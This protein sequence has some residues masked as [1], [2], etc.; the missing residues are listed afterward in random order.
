MARAWPEALP[1][2][3]LTD[4][5]RYQLG[6]TKL[7]TEMDAPRPK[8]RRRFTAAPHRLSGQMKLD[9]AQSEALERFHEVTCAGGTLDFTWRH[10]V[11]RDPATFEWAEEPEIVS[12]EGTLATWSL[13]LRR[14]G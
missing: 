8:M 13:S 3:F 10:P 9:S 2:Q 5:F 7:T 4:G 6:R 1:D 14:V 12:V 11:T